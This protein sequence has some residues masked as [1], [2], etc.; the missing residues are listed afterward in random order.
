MKGCFWDSER[1]L[2]VIYIFCLSISTV[3]FVWYIYIYNYI[4]TLVMCRSVFRTN[5]KGDPRSCHTSET[6]IALEDL[7]DYELFRACGPLYPAF[8]I[9]SLTSYYRWY[10]SF[11]FFSP[12]FGGRIRIWLAHIFQSWVD[13][14]P[15]RYT[16]WLF[17]LLLNAEDLCP[18]WKSGAFLR[19]DDLWRNHMSANGGRR[20]VVGLRWIRSPWWSAW[21]CAGNW[22]WPCA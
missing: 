10:N 19:L 14:E 13:V 11:I 6:S 1:V 16:S 17:L 3:F 4:Y 15:P 9:E 22:I 2:F 7:N 5:P 20:Y 12:F 18:Q 21:V 8:A